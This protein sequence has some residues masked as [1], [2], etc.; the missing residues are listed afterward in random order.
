MKEKWP[1]IKG[2]LLT[3]VCVAG[4]VFWIQSFGDQKTLDA[5]VSKNQV[6]RWE[7]SSKEW[8]TLKMWASAD[9]R[10]A[11]ERDADDLLKAVRNLHDL[12]LKQQMASSQRQ[13][14]ADAQKAR[15]LS[16]KA[17]AAVPKLRES[18]RQSNDGL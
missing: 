11:F 17:N 7:F 13:L 1:L 12:R 9:S 2:V 16:D 10:Q 5:W 8:D 15:E 18:I 3:I 14:E 4:L 6:Q